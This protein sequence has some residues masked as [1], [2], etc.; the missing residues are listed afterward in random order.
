MK[1]KVKFTVLAVAIIVNVILFQ[2]LFLHGLTRDTVLQCESTVTELP[3]DA[4]I[5]P[6]TFN[7]PYFKAGVGYC[8]SK[9]KKQ[10]TSRVWL[11]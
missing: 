7:N 1:S 3:D 11:K 5:S 4:G 8:D 9:R 2:V 6:N 10:H